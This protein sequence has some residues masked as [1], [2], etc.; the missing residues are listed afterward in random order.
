[1]GGMHRELREFVEEASRALA[2]LDAERLEE[3]ALSCQALNRELPAGGISDRAD[4]ARQ[5]REAQRELE[6]FARVLGVTRANLTV[7]HRLCDLRRGRIEYGECQLLGWA[8]KG[9]E[10]GDN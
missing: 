3:L 8:G 9:N 5:A 2:A 4:M 6:V 7:I 10:H 1:M